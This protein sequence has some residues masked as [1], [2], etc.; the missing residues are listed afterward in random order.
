MSLTKMQKVKIKVDAL[1]YS[2][3]LFI[4]TTEELI[5]RRE[6][7]IKA[8][9]ERKKSITSTAGLLAADFDMTH[10]RGYVQGSKHVLEDLRIIQ[11]L[12]A[13]MEREL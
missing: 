11:D 7:D 4:E 3:N 6:A 9:E 5:K 13:K 1:S 12:V 2:V 10:V 8:T